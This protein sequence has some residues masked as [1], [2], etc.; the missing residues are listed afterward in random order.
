[1][2]MPPIDE[3]PA[4]HFALLREIAGRHGLGVLSMGMSDDF[5]IAVRFGAS[6]ESNGSSAL[7]QSDL[8]N[9]KCEQREPRSGCF[10]W[11]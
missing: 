9:C 8:P 2:C 4:L 6:A 3:E 5:E 11:R 1:M 7:T 10:A